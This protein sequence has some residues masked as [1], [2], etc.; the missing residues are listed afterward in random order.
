MK[1]EREAKRRKNAPNSSTRFFGQFFAKTV[2][3][4]A[5]N[6]KHVDCGSV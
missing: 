1:T 6:G 4:N 2:G 5:E 3:Q